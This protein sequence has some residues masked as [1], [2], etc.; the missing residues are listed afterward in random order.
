[1]ND[2]IVFGIIS[3]KKKMHYIINISNGSHDVYDLLFEKISKILGKF[4]EIEKKYKK[5][6]KFA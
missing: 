2:F 3:T 4:F 6:L 5:N 1:M